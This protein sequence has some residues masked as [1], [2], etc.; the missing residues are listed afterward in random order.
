MENEDSTDNISFAES[1]LK[2]MFKKENEF[3][4]ISMAD[5]FKDAL[6]S[7]LDGIK[8]LTS[9]LSK[10]EAKEKKLKVEAG[11]EDLNYQKIIKEADSL[12]EKSK[13]LHTNILHLNIEIE[14]YKG[15]ESRAQTRLNTAAKKTKNEDAIKG[16]ILSSH[17]INLV[18]GARKE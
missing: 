17:L 8:D 13:E 5:S 7:L 1:R 9:T 11:G 18:K 16:N 15:K 14:N 6:T 12:E 10:C 2:L 4:V 3:G